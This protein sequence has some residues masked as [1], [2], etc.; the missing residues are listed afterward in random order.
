MF[1][2]KK[3]LAKQADA[4]IAEAEVT[5]ALARKHKLNAGASEEKIL[6]AKSLKKREDFELASSKARWVVSHLEGRIKKERSRLIEN[7]K[8]DLKK[9]IEELER[10]GV[11]TDRLKKLLKEVNVGENEKDFDNAVKSVKKGVALSADILDF[12][13]R[14]TNSLARARQL[15]DECE[16][17]GLFEKEGEKL[18]DEAVKC[19]ELTEFEEAMVKAATAEDAYMEKQQE[20]HQSRAPLD[21]LLQLVDS[22]NK[23]G[24]DL[25]EKVLE[26]EKL[27][28]LF[29][30][31]QY[32]EMKVE[33]DLVQQEI[34]G[35][36]EVFKET[37]MHIG[38]AENSLLEAGQ[39]GFSLTEPEAALEKAKENLSIGNLKEAKEL[40]LSVSESVA[41]LKGAH[42]KT[43]DTIKRLQARLQSVK[44]DQEDESLEVLMKQAE[45]SFYG[46]RYADADS[47]LGRLECEMDGR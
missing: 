30:S 42:K 9:R 1:G 17:L 8:R 34:T 13:Q 3:K 22:A 26:I 5:L 15:R 32:E 4:D 27:T 43:A 14:A 39:W 31:G 20:Y 35:R 16:K 23:L 21:A 45:D 41:G 37:T 6:E 36:M 33:V 44:K 25:S 47:F 29:E 28:G 38:L 18:L 24:L 46:G 12:C 2:K 19:L 10:V 11:D 40:A 7:R